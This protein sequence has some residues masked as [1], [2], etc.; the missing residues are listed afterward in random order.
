MR[1][2][3]L[4]L[5]LL[6]AGLCNT[7]TSACQFPFNDSRFTNSSQLADYIA[8]LQATGEPGVGGGKGW[9]SIIGQGAPV[10]VV[11]PKRGKSM[12]LVTIPYC[13]ASHEDFDNLK[14]VGK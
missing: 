5:L 10:R 12:K 2:L 13:Y 11:W 6:L 9:A 4:L 1:L 7:L 8:N 14:G 3:L